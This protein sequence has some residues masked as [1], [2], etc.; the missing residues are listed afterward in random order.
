MLFGALA[1]F[2]YALFATRLAVAAFHLRSPFGNPVK[3]GDSESRSGHDDEHGVCKHT[4]LEEVTSPFPPL[5]LYP[6]DPGDP[7]VGLPGVN[8][9]VGGIKAGIGNVNVSIGNVSVAAGNIELE[10]ITIGNVT[11]IV[12]VAFNG[13]NA[14]PATA[15]T[16]SSSANS[17]SSSTSAAGSTTS[18][19]TT[20]TITPTTTPDAL[21]NAINRRQEDTTSGGSSPTTTIDLPAP[22]V[23]GD[24]IGIGVGPVDASVGN[25]TIAVGNINVTLGDI[26]IK[27]VTIGNVFVLIQL[28]DPLR[29]DSIL[30]NLIDAV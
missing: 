7:G 29:N 18:T 8:A 22:T 19:S 21:F 5:R 28:G 14:G 23:T 10:N 13:G 2:I 20:S 6:R 11:V 25:I 1:A 9:S 30:N 26:S 3:D 12:S 27:N 15:T 16:I 4:P 17:I 24:P